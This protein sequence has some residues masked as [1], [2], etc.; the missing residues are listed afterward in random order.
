[1]SRAKAELVCPG[2]FSAGLPL[3]GG[4]VDLRVAVSGYSHSGFLQAPSR[5]RL[6][7]FPSRFRA[8]QKGPAFSGWA[9]LEW[10][11][12]ELRGS[13]LEGMVAVRNRG[14][15]GGACASG[16]RGGLRGG[17]RACIGVRAGSRIPSL[18]CGSRYTQNGPAPDPRQWRPAACRWRLLRYQS[19]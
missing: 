16:I 15:G 1:M 14:Q 4:R 17:Y 3:P 8:Q 9:L 18:Q 11:T 13:H 19:R 7:R 2:E 12:F 5:K 10:T 6:S